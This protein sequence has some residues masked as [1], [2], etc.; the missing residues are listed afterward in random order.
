MVMTNLYSAHLDEKVW[1]RPQEF[2]P[3]RFIDPKG[4]L[5]K[6]DL[7]IPFGLG[8]NTKTTWKKINQAI[9]IKY[10]NIFGRFLRERF[11][12]FIRRARGSDV[13]N[14]ILIMEFFKILI[15]VLNI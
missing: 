4:R 10:F 6:Q 7:S 11:I 1:D 8:K 3:E 9:C 12:Y 14:L 15:I 13:Q 5:K 2:R